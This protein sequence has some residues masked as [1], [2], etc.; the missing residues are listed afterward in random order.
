[1]ETKFWETNV[2]Y[3][4]EDLKKLN[5]SMKIFIDFEKLKSFINFGH[6]MEYAAS[7]IRNK[8][9]SVNVVSYYIVIIIVF[10]LLQLYSWMK[11]D[12]TFK[13]YWEYCILIDRWLKDKAQAM[14]KAAQIDIIHNGNEQKLRENNEWL[15]VSIYK[16]I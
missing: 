2:D 5:Y 10:N 11:S 16:I 1:V 15:E 8:A 7:T 4:M 6:K 14:K 3:T 13:P 9:K 12:I